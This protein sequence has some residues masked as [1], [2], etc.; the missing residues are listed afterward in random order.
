MIRD[1]FRREREDL[2]EAIREIQL[3][4]GLTELR[5]SEPNVS[6]EPLALAANAPGFR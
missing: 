2:L 6:R 1:N 5:W 3:L 4:S